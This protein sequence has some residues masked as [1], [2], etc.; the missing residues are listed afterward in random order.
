MT[1]IKGIGQWT[2]RYVAMRAFSWPDI[3]LVSDLVIKQT[4]VNVLNDKESGLLLKELET[5]MSKYRFNKL[6]EDC[7]TEYGIRFKPWR[8][9]LTLQLWKDSLM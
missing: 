6:Y 1:K 8:S 7:A 5:D 4:L 9:Y 2:A 3:L